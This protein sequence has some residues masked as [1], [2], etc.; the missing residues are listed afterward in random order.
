MNIHIN[1]HISTYICICIYMNIHIKVHIYLNIYVYVCTYIGGCNRWV[2]QL[3]GMFNG[4]RNISDEVKYV[5][6]ICLAEK[7][8]TC[9]SGEHI[10]A[11][12]DN[13]RKMAAA[14]LPQTTLTKFLEAKIEQRLA[15]AYSEASEKHNIPIES[16]EKCPNLSLRLVSS[17]DKSHIVREGVFE[18]YK[19]KEY[20]SEFPCRTKCLVLFHNMSMNTDINVPHLISD[21]CT[22][23][24]LI[25]SIISDL[26]NT[27]L[28]STMKS[29]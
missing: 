28:W 24:I 27:E 20:P 15:L 14:N 18:R 2:H 10:I 11:P 25:R 21:G 7:R 1:V 3:C 13:N 19:H 8:R 29:L 17:Y 6:P 16:V 12:L 9:T 26:S 22:Y 4:R 23:P 5:C